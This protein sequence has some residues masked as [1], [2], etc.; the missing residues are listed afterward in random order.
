MHICILSFLTLLTVPIR[1]IPQL[2][3]TCRSLFIPC[4]LPCNPEH[5]FPFL[6][7][8]FFCFLSMIFHISSNV[9]VNSKCYQEL[10]WGV[11][12]E[13]KGRSLFIFPVSRT[14]VT[15][16]QLVALS[17]PGVSPSV[18][19]WLPEGF[20]RQLTL[21]SMTIVSESQMVLLHRSL[22][23]LEQRRNSC[24]LGLLGNFQ[25]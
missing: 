21:S 3:L 25:H 18:C 20:G 22:V 16:Y 1:I 17:H 5:W 4:P 9:A 11:S 24:V 13:T 7:W 14:P 23:L 10:L 6:L 15:V 19:V 2:H 8:N 12:L